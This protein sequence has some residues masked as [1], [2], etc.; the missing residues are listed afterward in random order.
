VVHQLKSLHITQ[1]RDHA[2]KMKVRLVDD[3]ANRH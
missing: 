2:S 1:V 3:L